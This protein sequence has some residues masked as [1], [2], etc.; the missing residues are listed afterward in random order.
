MFDQAELSGAGESPS[1]VDRLRAAARQEARAAAERLNAIWDLYI[2]K[3]RQFG[4]SEKWAADTF[5]AVA[6][7][8]AAALNISLGQASRHV[9]YARVMGERLPKVGAVFL[10]GDIDFRLFQTIAFRTELITDPDALAAVDA[11]I[12]R[13]ARRWTAMTQRKLEKVLDKLVFSIDKDAVRRRKQEAEDRD[14]WIADTRDGMAGVC[15]SLFATDAH[16][17]DER[18]D[19]LA[20]T[21]CEADPRTHHQRRADA[22]GA[23]AAGSDRLACQCGAPECGAANNPPASNVVIHVV[24]EQGTVEGRGDTPACLVGGEELIPA[25][26]VADLAKQARIRPLFDARAAAP[27]P[28]YT[29]S[30]K[31]AEFVQTRDLTCRAPGCDRPATHCDIDHTVAFA[32]GGLTHASNL[33]C[34]CRLHHLLKTFWG[35]RDQ[36][37]PDGTIIWRLPGNQT[38]VTTPG[39]ALLFPTLCTPTAPLPPPNPARAD[40]RGDPT[41]MMPIRKTTRAQNRAHSIQAE[42]HQNQQR[43]EARRA[44]LDAYFTAA[45]PP[46]ENDE[47]PPF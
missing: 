36:Q 28:G 41:V 42:R 2:D 17:L 12:A 4:E 23:L 14:V 37:L 20:T 34:L 38:Y 10:A 6:A 15:G 26:L 22:L 5:A 47:P 44:R 18:L 46:G 33:K 1:A 35:W 9:R 16:A 27:E 25:D 29:P 11:Q 3:V 43:R 45:P 40:R 21:V 19:A 31:L 13:R 24:A 7:E 32:D 39:S 30:A 8:V